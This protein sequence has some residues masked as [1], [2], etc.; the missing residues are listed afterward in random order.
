MPSTVNDVF[1]AAGVRPSGC[2][3]WSV[4]VPE[5]RC[6]VYLVALTDERDS[7]SA[8]LPECPIA[9]DKVEHL[10]GVRPELR[11]DG[12]RRCRPDS[13]VNRRAQVLASVG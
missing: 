13:G 9:I 2:V 12:V 8:A 7:V 11:L 5:D 6:G 1:G 3:P 4:P 10:L